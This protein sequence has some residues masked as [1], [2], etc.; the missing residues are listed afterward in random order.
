MVEQLVVRE[1][2]TQSHH[3]PRRCFGQAVATPIRRHCLRQL[4]ARSCKNP[5]LAIRWTTGVASTND[6]RNASCPPSCFFG[7]LLCWPRYLPI[8]SGMKVAWLVSIIGTATYMAY[9]IALILPLIYPYCP[10]K[11][12]LTLYVYSLYQLVHDTLIPLIIIIRRFPYACVFGRHSRFYLGNNRDW[13][14]DFIASYQRSP[15][16]KEIERIMFKGVLLK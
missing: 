13:R 16:V 8:L 15:T 12:P 5:T 9:I 6:H 4:R 14:N 1:S 7:A 11:V 3:C 10:F 2:D